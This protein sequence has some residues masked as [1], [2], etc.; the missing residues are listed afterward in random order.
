M[1]K[2]FQLIVLSLFAAMVTAVAGPFSWTART[3]GD[4]L[5]L[6]ADVVPG[7]YFYANDGFEFKIAG[8]DGRAA[9][10][11]SAP[12]P[13]DVEDEFMGKV[14]VFPGGQW[15]WK[16]RGEPP[17]SGTVDYHGCR[18]AAEGKPALCF[19]PETF[20][21]APSG[22]PA[23]ATIPAAAGNALLDRF[24]LV[25][26]TEGLQSVAQF[27]EFLAPNGNAVEEKTGGMFA[28]TALWLVIL[29]TLAGGLG[30]NLTPCVL[31]MIP[32]NLAIIGADGAGR[33]AGFR[34]G[35]SYGIGMA[36]AYGILGVVVILTGARFGELNS[37]SVFNFVIAAVFA[38][39]AT[40]MFGFFN[41]DFS[42]KLRISPKKVKGGKT[43]VAFVMGALAALL[44]G[45]C[46]APV[47][48]G[49]LLFSAQLYTEGNY[50]ALGLPF[51]LGVG[52][53]L[54]WPLAGAGFGVLP[55]PGNFMVII[56]YVFGGIITLAALWYAWVGY[57]LL[58]GD[59]SPQREM[60]ALNRGLADSE[61]SGKPVMIDFWATWCKN[62]K[63]MER[64]VFPD[65]EI[66]TL[67]KNYEVV[68]FQAEKLRDPEVKALLDRYGIPGLPA[69]VILKAK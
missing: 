62:C 65:P 17:F 1:K 19:M 60:A 9:K 15:E 18:K 61:R 51:L 32:V 29:L 6:T 40:A 53:A 37:S 4:I 50:F 46:V 54:P 58:P 36:A 21:I 56:K 59:F 33:A 68:K 67:L 39:L 26:K 57:T 43:V 11:E 49:V 25:R 41:L 2:R 7:H 12:S 52:M 34:R 28:G 31:P 69:F 13:V 64:D 8:K 27:K 16:F 30:L 55:K 42:G 3:D 48:I 47:V 23:A 35:L 24:T 45:A 63:E 20:E 22:E 44:A 14:K 10:L 5:T 38:L 66:Q